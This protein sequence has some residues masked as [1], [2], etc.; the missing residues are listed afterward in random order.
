MS[1]ETWSASRTAS[2]GRG[3]ALPWA[4]I[5]ACPPDYLPGFA[6]WAAA[7]RADE[8]LLV[9]GAQYVR[10]SNHN[11]AR[12]RTPEG[13]QWLTIPVRR[14]QFR[15][16]LREMEI[17]PEGSWWRHH[18]KALQYNY[19]S[20][21]FYEH[22]MPELR[23][24][25]T[26]EATRLIE[27]SVPLIHLCAR[28][29]QCEAAFRE[30]ETHAEGFGRSGG[31]AKSAVAPQ[32]HALAHPESPGASPHPAPTYRQAFEGFVPGL[33]IIDLLFNHGPRARDILLREV[34]H[35]DH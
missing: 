33:S 9:T 27:V 23:P 13:A 20:T 2:T 26:A 28:W 30:V 22:L 11:R 31:A 34:L 24:Y 25:L 18:S 15:S 29:L 1:H 19:G 35:G 3:V 32:P 17:S 4:V 5:F 14:G 6:F 16:P 10:Q 7:L 12:V 21:P 8:V